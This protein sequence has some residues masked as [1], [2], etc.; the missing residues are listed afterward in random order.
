LAGVIDRQPN[1]CPPPNF[2]TKVI[3][4]SSYKCWLEEIVGMYL[5]FISWKLFL[6]FSFRKGANFGCNGGS[7]DVGGVDV[8]VPPQGGACADKRRKML[9]NQRRKKKNQMRKYKKPAMP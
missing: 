4:I 5:Y 8:D 2:P 3:K 1:A 7:D 9:L 6:L